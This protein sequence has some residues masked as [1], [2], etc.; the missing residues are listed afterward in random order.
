MRKAEHEIIGRVVSKNV[1]GYI[2]RERLR[3]VIEN[4][5][6]FDSITVLLYVYIDS[7]VYKKINIYKLIGASKFKV[8]NNA[9]FRRHIL[10]CIS[11]NNIED[12][13]NIN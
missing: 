13:I 3:K 7:Q 8:I 9:D 5:F 12:V 2:R 10:Y 11:N 6:R 1:A 4:L